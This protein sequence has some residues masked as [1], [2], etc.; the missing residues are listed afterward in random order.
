MTIFGSARSIGTRS[1]PRGDQNAQVAKDALTAADVVRAALELLDEVGLQGFTMRA[2]AQRLDT[3]PATIYWHVGSRHA[4]LSGVNDL[5]LVGAFGD[6]PDPEGLEWADWL[7]ALA[8]AFRGA[9]HEHPA[10]AAFA[11]GHLEAGVAVPETLEALT[12]VLAQAGFRGP[13]LTG[14]YNTYLGSLIGWVA[15]ELIPDDPEIGFDPEAMEASVRELPSE[16][17]PTLDAQR[18]LLADQA[19]AFRWH[20]GVS[21][22]M[23]DA[24]AFALETWIGG[25]RHH[26]D[27]QGT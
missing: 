8:H 2:L 21:R 3:Y 24:F 13:A 9:M 22:P 18:E 7:R 14:A 12:L 20:G 1:D 6:L 16:P 4:V 15:L 17:Y 5:V 23:D 10:L 27:R 25:L 26:P 19:F 11:V